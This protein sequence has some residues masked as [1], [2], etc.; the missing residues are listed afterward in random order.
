MW[1]GANRPSRT[2]RGSPIRVLKNEALQTVLELRLL[3]Q[4]LGSFLRE[5][6]GVVTSEG[7]AVITAE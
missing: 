2:P 1:S 7:M 5:G 6:L 4:L 3:L